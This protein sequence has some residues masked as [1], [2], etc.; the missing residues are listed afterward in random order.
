M[1]WSDNWS[2]WENKAYF[3]GGHDNRLYEVDMESQKYYCIGVLTGIPEFRGNPICR[4]IDDRIILFPDIGKELLIFS[5]SNSGVKHISLDK[6]N[7]ERFSIHFSWVDGGKLYFV[8]DNVSVIYVVDLA[9]E[10]LERI[11]KINEEHELLNGYETN[12]VKDVLYVGAANKGVIYAVNL[13]N[14]T[15]MTYEINELSSGIGTLRFD[16]DAFWITGKKKELIKWKPGE[17]SQ[18]IEGYSDCFGIYTNWIS[19]FNTLIDNHVSEA[20]NYLFRQ[21]CLMGDYIWLIP[22]I[23]SKIVRI[24]LKNGLVSSFDMP[25][26]EDDLTGLDGE[27]VDMCIKYVLEYYRENRY[28]GVYSIKTNRMFEIDASEGKANSVDFCK[29]RKNGTGL[30][31]GWL[32]HEMGL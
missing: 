14:D 3:V 22:F 25:E 26:S 8:S 29:V 24:D 31:L 12:V 17:T 19:S 30:E 7:Q 2:I 10:Q 21:S 15:I 1:E 6:E 16:G 20:S 9:K 5:M 27:W 18:I 23:A 32:F 11:I 28:L 13:I 4:R